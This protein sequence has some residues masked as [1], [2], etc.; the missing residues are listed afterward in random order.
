MIA[1]VDFIV[2]V[3]SVTGLVATPVSIVTAFAAV[4]I[5]RYMRRHD[6][7]SS[8]ADAFAGFLMA[9]AVIAVLSLVHFEAEA[10][11]SADY[12]YAVLIV[13]IAGPVSGLMVGHIERRDI[14]KDLTRN[15][16]KRFSPIRRW[17]TY[18]TLFVASC[19]L[20]GDVTTLIYN[21]LGGELT[22]RLILK[23]VPVGAIAGTVF[24]YYLSDL[25]R[26]ERE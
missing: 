18:L 19:V 12:I 20:I 22:S 16:V 1:P 21:A 2:M 9:C 25:R 4:P 24:G 5:F 10:L 17:L 7:R 11:V 15:P 6:Y 23:V 13:L 8:R 3:G 26:E 14:G